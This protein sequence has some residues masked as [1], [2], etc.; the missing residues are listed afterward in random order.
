MGSRPSDAIIDVWTAKAEATSLES[1]G[2][3]PTFFAEGGIVN[4][5]VNAIVGEAGAEAI[6]P[7]KNGSGL[8]VDISGI[9]SHLEALIQKQSI[10]ETNIREIKD[11]LKRVAR[12]DK[13]A[14]S[15]TA[16]A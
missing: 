5:P 16:V 15:V 8:K 3:S 2:V 6:I 11:I 4:K 7:L 14:L 10:T 9:V 1:I 12:L 13:G